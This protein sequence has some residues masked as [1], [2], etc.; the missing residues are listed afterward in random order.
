MTLTLIP[1]AVDLFTARLH[2]CHGYADTLIV[3]V[4]EVVVTRT[5]RW[6]IAV[7]TAHPATPAPEPAEHWATKL[8]RNIDTTPSPSTPAESAGRGEG[9]RQRIDARLNPFI[10]GEHRLTLWEAAENTVVTPE[11]VQAAMERMWA[12]PYR[13]RIHWRRPAAACPWDGSGVAWE[14]KETVLPAAWPVLPLRET[15]ENPARDPGD[16]RPRGAGH[17]RAGTNGA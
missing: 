7:D 6:R 5:D 16:L 4:T 14:P 15:K 17:T 3:A 9:I 8:R 2:G 11:A 10:F 12:E 13:P 1:G